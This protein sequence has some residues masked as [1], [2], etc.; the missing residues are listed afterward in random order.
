MA[1]SLPATS[2]GTRPPVPAWLI[3]PLL[4]LMATALSLHLLWQASPPA[5]WLSLPAR[6]AHELKAALVFYGLLPRFAVAILAGAALGL[7]GVLMQRVL[8][9]PIAEPSTLGVAAGA[10]LALSV[11]IVLAPGLLA[12]GRELV[13]VAGALLT[14]ALV[15]ALSWRRGLDP[16]TVVISGSLVSMIAGALGAAL[17][18][19]NGE[20]L[21]SLMVWGGGE[22]SQQSWQPALGLAWRLALAGFAAFL[23]LRPLALLGLDDSRAKGLGLAVTATRLGILLLAVWLAASVTAA[24]GIIGFIGLAAPAFARLAGAHSQRRLLWAAPLLGALLLWL[25]DSLLLTL[26]GT[27]ASLPTGAITALFG[28]P[29]LLWMLPRLHGANRPHLAGLPPALGRTAHP[30]RLIVLLVLALITF[31]LIGLMVGQDTAGWNIAGFDALHALL[32]WRW[33]RLV[34]AVAAGA[35]LAAAGTICQ[36]LTGNPL[37]SPEV[38]G[39]GAGAGV[40]ITASLFLLPVATPLSMLG[41]AAAGAAIALLFMLAVAAR[42]GFGPERLL[43]AGIA[44]GAFCG[45]IISAVMASGD[46]RTFVLLAWLSGDNSAVTPMQAGL[47]AAVALLL[48]APLPLLGRWLELLPLGAPAARASG[49]PVTRS[50]LVLVLLAA[51]LTAAGCLTVGPLSLVGLVA[52]HLARLIGFT[53]ARSQLVAAVLMGAV[54]MALT[55]WLSRTLIFPYQI[56][57]GLTA[58][59]IGGPYLIWFLTRRRAA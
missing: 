3:W 27:D 10:K 2:A 1:E 26:A 39:I 7:A 22:L 6:A 35:M 44:T 55:D 20:Y 53:R 18:L 24:V 34:S 29:L 4:G 37:A 28:G 43:L 42:S 11:G 56:P 40:G 14:M 32:P 17:T 54:L 57:S 30:L 21:M 59:L 48:L 9:N 38:L 33:P 19:A 50:R 16:V 5:D 46:F 51:L 25:T 41:F 47:S 31:A 12:E 52:P 13:A 15:L 45:A 49:L 23:L 36:R 58:S 8:R